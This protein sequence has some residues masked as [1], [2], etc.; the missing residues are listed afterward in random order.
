MSKDP[1]TAVRG[2]QLSPF[3][4]GMLVPE[5][6]EA[7]IRLKPGEISD[8]V[9][10]QFG[11]HIIKKTGQKQLPPQSFEDVKEDIRARLE[12]VKFDQWVT[13]KESTMGVRTN[14]KEM[15]ALAAEPIP[16]AGRSSQEP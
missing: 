1:S 16:D 11:F 13:S 10:T 3:R 4:R 6:E 2:G 14:E 15:D 8:V 12:R 9:K 7:A 5:F